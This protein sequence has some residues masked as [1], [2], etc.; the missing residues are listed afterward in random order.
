MAKLKYTKEQIAKAYELYK[1]LGTLAKVSSVTGIHR[2]TLSDNFDK[3]GFDYNKVVKNVALK[4]SDE[5]IQQAYDLYLS[6]A[7]SLVLA[8]I[9]NVDFKTI[10]KGFKNKNLKI[11]SNKQNSR[12]YK[13]ANEDYFENIDSQDKAY[14][15]GFIY[16]DGYIS[17]RGS[18]K[19]FGVALSTKD[20]ELLIKLNDCLGSNYQIK[21][22]TSKEN[23]EY[24]SVKYS[25]LL[26]TSDKIVDDLINLGVVEHKT[27]IA[28]PPNIDY[29]LIRHFIRGYMDGDGSITRSNNDY[30]VSFLGTD[31]IL[32]YISQYLLS[33]RLINKVNAF[34]KRRSGQI[35]S[36]VVYGGNLQSQKILDHLYQ[37]S[38]MFL[39]RKYNKYKDLSNHNCRPYK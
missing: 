26:I 28:K 37:D 22:Y 18:Q 30:R 11:R 5:D 34:G 24:K 1:E 36:N 21:R 19:C 14:W 35:V 7:S 27:N 8:K 9:F 20:E 16:A 29:E 31:D 4:L 13:V 23:G 3:Y 2:R 17:I 25:R 15:L 33:Q 6:G 38:N 12:I 32:L 39:S 10:L